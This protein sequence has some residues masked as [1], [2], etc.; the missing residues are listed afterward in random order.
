MKRPQQSL[1]VAAASAAEAPLAILDRK[2]RLGQRL[3]EG[4]TGV[5]YRAVH[6]GLK[7]AFAV[8]LLQASP[9]P[10]SLARFRREA[11][12]LGQ[13]RHRHVVE[14]TD[15]GIDDAAGGVPYLVLELLEGISLADL[16]RQT[17]PLPLAR[18]LPILE[19]IA[20][21]VDTAHE[22]GILHRDLKPGNVLLC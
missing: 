10:F 21:A 19:A 18:A 8:K 14:V 9:D 1:P 22:R 3:G 13:L 20:A 17:G 4:A 16:C 2:Y 7:K 12:A 15:F 6:L 11:E 5:V